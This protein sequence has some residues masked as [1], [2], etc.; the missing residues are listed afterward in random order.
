MTAPHKPGGAR[1]ADQGLTF[2]CATHPSTR[3]KRG[4]SRARMSFLGQVAGA[5]TNRSQT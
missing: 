4:N 1:N 5:R 3:P 2:R